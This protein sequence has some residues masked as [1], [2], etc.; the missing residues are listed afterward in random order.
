MAALEGTIVR[1]TAGTSPRPSQNGAAMIENIFVADAITLLRHNPDLTETELQN[2]IAAREP[3]LSARNVEGVA[4]EALRQ[5]PAVKAAD[6]A[7]RERVRRAANAT[8]AINI[9]KELAQEAYDLNEAKLAT[10]VGDRD[11]TLSS[12]E[13][14]DAAKA[15]LQW[16]HQQ[17]DGWWENAE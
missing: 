7:E 11:I 17:V 8:H 14:L 9:V 6:D 1:T 4:R 5:W 10:L 12:T 15:G 16:L 13:M 2:E 3:L